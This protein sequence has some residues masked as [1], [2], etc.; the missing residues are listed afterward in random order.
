MGTWYEKGQKSQKVLS[1]GSISCF[2][3]VPVRIQVEFLDSS[4]LAQMNL[5]I[6]QL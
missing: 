5:A 4:T 3:Q 6:S 1:L 2:H